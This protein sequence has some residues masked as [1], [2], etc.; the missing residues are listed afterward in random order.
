M[1]NFPVKH[2][3]LIN[4]PGVYI[5][6]SLSFFVLWCYQQVPDAYLL[7]SADPVFSCE[8]EAGFPPDAQCAPVLETTSLNG[9]ITKCLDIPVRKSGSGKFRHC[10]RVKGA[11]NGWI[12]SGAGT[13]LLGY[14]QT[15]LILQS[16]RQFDNPFI[17][18]FFHW[19]GL[20]IKPQSV[21]TLSIH[22]CYTWWFCNI[23]SPWI[24]TGNCTTS[25]P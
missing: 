18:L 22:D 20:Y 15:I 6:L 5:D 13:L 11:R 12:N 8:C 23:P 16:I 4:L 25:F 17:P 7:S 24:W 10:G 19:S 9:K 21:E 3:F 14:Y 1:E 2:S